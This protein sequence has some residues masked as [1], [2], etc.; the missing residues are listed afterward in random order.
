MVNDSLRYSLKF[1]KLCENTKPKYCVKDMISNQPIECYPLNGRKL[2]GADIIL[3][4]IVEEMKLI[5]YLIYL[6]W[7]LLLIYFEIDRSSI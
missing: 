4:S 2:V 1:N 6:Q 5:E 3:M 7:S